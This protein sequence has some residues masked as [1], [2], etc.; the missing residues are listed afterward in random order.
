MLKE[1]LNKLKFLVEQ[2]VVF[3]QNYRALGGD[4]WYTKSSARKKS[5]VIYIVI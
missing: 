1:N 3:R 4:R 2:F 5:I